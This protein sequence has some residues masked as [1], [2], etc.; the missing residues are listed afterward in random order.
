MLGTNCGAGDL[1]RGRA[2]SGA[3]VVLVVV[4]LLD[5]GALGGA[6]WEGGGGGAGRGAMVHGID[7]AF[8]DLALVR[9]RSWLVCLSSSGVGLTHTAPCRGTS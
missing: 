9:E 5:W 2:G 1:E 8:T 7:T 4:L 3:G 6:V